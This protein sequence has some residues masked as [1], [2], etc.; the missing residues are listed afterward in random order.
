M[1]ILSRYSVYTVAFSELDYLGLF[2]CIVYHSPALGLVCRSHSC[3]IILL[4]AR[5]DGLTESESHTKAFFW[6]RA[7]PED[8]HEG[9]ILM[10]MFVLGAGKGDEGSCNRVMENIKG[11]PMR[12]F[13]R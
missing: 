12:A 1:Y 5:N 6:G 4:Q 13:T 8:E 9:E 7:A 10:T 11:G 3:Y 2:L